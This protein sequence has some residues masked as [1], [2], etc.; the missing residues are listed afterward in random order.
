MAE[1]SQA[2]LQFDPRL[3]FAMHT[4]VPLH[5]TSQVLP[6]SQSVLH[7]PTLL[8]LTS[9]TLL[10][11]HTETHRRLEEQSKLQPPQDA[12]QAELQSWIVQ[13]CSQSGGSSTTGLSSISKRLQ[14]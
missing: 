6:S 11:E 5:A 4:A 3:H 1:P 2:N 12:S 14:P 9:Q 8:Q 10:S 7:S 13:L